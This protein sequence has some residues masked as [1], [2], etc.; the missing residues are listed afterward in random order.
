MI[1][2]LDLYK[3]NNKFRKDLEASFS[4]SL[5]DSYYIL[6]YNVEKFET[7]FAH[8]CDTKYCIGTGNGLDAL[9]LIFK[10]YIELG[11]LKKEDK[12]IVPA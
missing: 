1:K 6:G 12:V 8:Y 7:E 9:T 10:G 3:I 11:K 5:D 4:K 2:F